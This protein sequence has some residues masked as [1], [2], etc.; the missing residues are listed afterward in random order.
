LYI[1]SVGVL[2]VLLVDASNAERARAFF[3]R[4]LTGMRVTPSA[5]RIESATFDIR[6]LKVWRDL[7]GA[8]AFAVP[9]VHMLDLDEARNRVTIGVVD[10]DSR[11]RLLAV[12]AQWPVPASALNVI[13]I[14][15]AA[16]TS[17]LGGYY[18]PLVGGLYHEFNNAGVFA[19]GCS[20]A[21]IVA[22][23]GRLRPAT[24]RFAL[25]AS[26]CT[27]SLMAYDGWSAYQN[28]SGSGCAANVI[29]TEAIDPAP[30]PA[31]SPYC[32]NTGYQCQWF[33]AALIRLND[34]SG[35]NA[36]PLG[37][38][39]RTGSSGLTIGDTT[40]GVSPNDRFRVIAPGTID[41]WNYIAIVGNPL[42]KMG[43]KSGWTS[44]NITRTCFSVAPA[45]TPNLNPAVQLLCQTEAAGYSDHG[46]SGA[47]VFRLLG[48]TDA[49][50]RQKVAW[51][52]V[53]C[54]NN[55]QNGVDAGGNTLPSP[56]IFSEF[57]FIQD[58]LG[59]DLY[60]TP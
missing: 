46:D 23:D 42:S 52:G 51:A 54:C 2:H 8:D 3:A 11:A 35:T 48:E 29:G 19:G 58:G 53:V 24:S 49:N 1:D 33:D 6:D 47:P 12:A 15:R 44:G 25:T 17:K 26:H 10:A 4:Q 59:F 27:R 57:D 37:Y 38:I 31:S 21:L 40:I 18:R 45:Y 16:V 34:S 50:G 60:W 41:M 22:D 7:I 43:F 36:P 9:G 28:C 20:L 5:I 30:Y 14:P 39:A 13:V 56:T 32:Q 55:G